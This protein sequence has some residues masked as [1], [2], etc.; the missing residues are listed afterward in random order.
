M[1]NTL[2]Y[3]LKHCPESAVT[4]LICERYYDPLHPENKTVKITNKRDKWAR[5]Y[6]GEKWEV[7]RKIN[8]I[9]TVLQNN[10][11]VLDEFYKRIKRE[12]HPFCDWSEVRKMWDKNTLP[13]KELQDTAEEILTNQNFSA[14]VFRKKIKNGYEDDDEQ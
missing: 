8:A 5:V 1:C 9:N 14:S 12:M 3:L 2:R 7:Q 11:V 4:D 10:F 6:N 13:N